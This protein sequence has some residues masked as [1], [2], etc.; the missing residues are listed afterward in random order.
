MNQSS[1]TKYPSLA[2]NNHNHHSLSC[3]RFR[4]CCFPIRFCY[5][6]ISIS[7]F[8]YS[9]RINSFIPSIPI[10]FSISLNLLSNSLD[11]PYHSLMYPYQLSASLHSQLDSQFNFKIL[12]FPILDQSPITQSNQAFQHCYS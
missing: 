2:V 11:S 9:N 12:L 7:L 6:P 4:F 5:S 10:L 3:N 1:Q 8:N